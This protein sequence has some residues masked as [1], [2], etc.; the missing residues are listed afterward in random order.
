MQSEW[1]AACAGAGATSRPHDV[2][3]W[4]LRTDVRYAIEMITSMI[5]F[6]FRFW[7]VDAGLARVHAIWSDS[8]VVYAMHC[9]LPEG[10][11]WVWQISVSTGIASTL[12]GCKTSTVMWPQADAIYR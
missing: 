3:L 4:P 9:S 12:F 8:V 7:D 10:V 2:A 1:E 11:A 5:V 6:G